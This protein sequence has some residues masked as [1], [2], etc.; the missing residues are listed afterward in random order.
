MTGSNSSKLG[1]A[2]LSDVIMMIG[3]GAIIAIYFFIQQWSNGISSSTNWAFWNTFV[4][5]ASISILLYACFRFTLRQLNIYL[6]WASSI[7]KRVIVEIPLIIFIA[8]SLMWLF[9]LAYFQLFDLGRLTRSQLIQNSMIAVFVSLLVNAIYELL[10]LYKQLKNSQLE[11]EQLR[12]IQVETHFESLKNQFAPHFLFNSLNTLQALI[13]ENPKDAGAFVHKLANY[14]RYVLKINEQ[15]IVS[16]ET[17]LN[18]VTDYVFLLKCR[19]G[20]KLNVHIN[21]PNQVIPDAK[22]IPLSVQLLV[23]NAVKHNIISDSKP[24]NIFININPQNIQVT[25]AIQKRASNVISNGIG[26]ENIRARYEMITNEK[27]VVTENLG[28]FEVQLPLIL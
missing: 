22:V 20:N 28:Q 12:R 15:N 2:I 7:F 18:H 14:Y 26:L 19:F 9:S 25:N 3:V 6:P 24:L 13:E 11:A 4:F 17:E 23:E 10:F 5:S 1:K 16:L 27:M 8:A 21:P